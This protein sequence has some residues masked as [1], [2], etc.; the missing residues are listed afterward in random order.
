MNPHNWTELLKSS[1]APWLPRADAF[2]P[3]AYA[4]PDHTVRTAVGSTC[5]LLVID[6]AHVAGDQLGYKHSVARSISGSAIDKLLAMPVDRIGTGSI[7]DLR[8]LVGPFHTPG[9]DTQ[10]ECDECDECDGTGEVECY[11]CGHKHDCDRCDGSGKVGAPPEEPP[12]RLL[13]VGSIT[14]DARLLAQMVPFLPDGPVEVGFSRTAGN[15][16][17]LR[18]IG[19]G[20]ELVLMRLSSLPE[21]KCQ[22]TRWDVA[23]PEAT[24]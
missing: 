9:P 23:N 7:A 3:F 17:T 15:F 14:F 2:P 1:G 5:V 21:E 13:H 8:A 6:G 16:A 10:T 4:R 18:L 11:A 19:A 20:W 12:M 24:V 22:E